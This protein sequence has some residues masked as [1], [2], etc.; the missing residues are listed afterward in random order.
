MAGQ[1]IDIRLVASD[2][3]SDVVDLTGNEDIVSGRPLPQRRLSTGAKTRRLIQVAALSAAAL[4]LG[5]VTILHSSTQA[6][7]AGAPTARAAAMAETQG[8]SPVLPAYQQ[9][10]NAQRAGERVVAHSGC[11]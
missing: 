4:T 2:H 10:W 6:P 5:A 1:Q 9:D 11:P 8:S 3:P 7:A